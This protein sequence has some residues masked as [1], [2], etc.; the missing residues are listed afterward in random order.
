[1]YVLEKNSGIRDFL[2]AGTFDPA[3]PGV[4]DKRL[5]ESDAEP[6]ILIS[7][8]EFGESAALLREGALHARGVT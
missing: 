5:N 6:D 2:V 3:A 8:C 7:P 4:T 1:M